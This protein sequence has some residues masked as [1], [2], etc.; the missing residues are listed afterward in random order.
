M[1][2]WFIILAQDLT[3]EGVRRLVVYARDLEDN[4]MTE[5]IQASIRLYLI[6]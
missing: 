6:L 5:R 4:K 1:T 2:N 3:N